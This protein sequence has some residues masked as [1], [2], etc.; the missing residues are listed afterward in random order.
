MIVKGRVAGGGQPP[1]ANFCEVSYGT[2]ELY[3]QAP[4]MWT[5]VNRLVKSDGDDVGLLQLIYT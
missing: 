2:D 4:I 5:L 1:M 3:Y